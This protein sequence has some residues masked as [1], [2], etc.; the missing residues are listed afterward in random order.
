[1]IPAGRDWDAAP[2]ATVDALAELRAVAP[3]GL[4]QSY[5][6]LLALNDG[7]E[8]PLAIQPF[9]FVLLSASQAAE[10][11]RDDWRRGSLPGLFE[12]VSNGAGE[13][14]AFDLARPDRVVM[15]DTC[16]GDLDESVVEL[17]P[18]LQ[19]FLEHVGLEGVGPT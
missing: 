14:I 15:F 3:P 18:D 11:W 9:S 8:G 19:R 6:D 4:P 17:A 5:F 2:G 7:G 12:I 1:M 10:S 16:N 13:A